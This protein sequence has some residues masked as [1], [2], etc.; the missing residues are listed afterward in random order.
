MR[1]RLSWTRAVDPVVDFATKF[2]TMDVL[3]AN[4]RSW[5]SLEDLDVVSEQL[6]AT[7][8]AT[9]LSLNFSDQTVGLF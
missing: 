6:V 5:R 2:A 3:L 8:G 7:A 9:G 4:F 1:R